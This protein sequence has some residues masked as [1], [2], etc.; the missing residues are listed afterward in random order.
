MKEEYKDKTKEQLIN[1]LVGLRQRIAELE[2]AKIECNKRVELEIRNFQRYN[3]GLIEASLGP[4]VTFDQRGTILDVNEATVQ[5][6]G[7]T[8]EELIG[9]LFPDYFTDPEKAHKG[10]MKAFET[11][12]VRDCELVM[13]AQD[14]TETV[15]VYNASVYKDQAGQVAGAFA[16]ARVITERKQAEEAL[17]AS[18]EKYRDLA[19][20]LPE[21]VFETDLEGNI[22]YANQVAFDF[23][24]YTQS[25]FDKGLNATQMLIPEDQDRGKESIQRVL[26]GETTGSREYTAQRKDKTTFP[27]IINSMPIIHEN[28][29]VGMRGVITDITE[30][31]RSEEEVKKSR[32]F[33]DTIIENIPDPL[34]IKDRQFRFVEV[35]KAFCR[36]HKV[37]KGKE[38]ILGETRYRETDEETFKTGKELEIPEQHYTDAEGNQHWTHLKKVPLTDESG[39]ITHVL[40]ISHDVTERKRAEEERG[41]L[42]QEL[43]DKNTELERFTYTVSHDL[44]YSGTRLEVHRKWNSKNGTP[45]E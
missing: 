11:G 12:K 9:T 34:Y 38:E 20:L 19:E 16:A 17:R 14:R 42:L 27:V 40:T 43:R 7:R 3:R 5:A 36:T 18:V 10:V 29:P 2:K 30:R 4:L 21:V 39:N 26:S 23:F 31:K 13:K 32:K 1:E 41:R 22:T 35:N 45:I 25:D 44:M 24:G 37:T 28:K 33:L 15:V 6:T 8:R